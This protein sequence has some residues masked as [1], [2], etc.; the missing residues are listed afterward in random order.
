M[1]DRLSKGVETWK[2]RVV[3]QPEGPGPLEIVTYRRLVSSAHS[4]SSTP[5]VKL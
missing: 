4:R 2:P 5:N 3:T 1:R